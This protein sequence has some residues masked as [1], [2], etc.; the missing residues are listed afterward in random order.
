MRA[1]LAF[2]AVVLAASGCSRPPDIDDVP[3]GSSVQVTRE[4]GALVEGRLS[5]RSADAVRVDVGPTTR[6]VP[7]RE[8]V[9]FRVKGPN[10]KDE[11]PPAARFREITVPAD[12]RMTVRLHVPVGSAISRPEEIVHGTL[13]RPIAV[14]GATVI[15]A[16]AEVFGVVTRAERA[17][18]VKGRA[19]LAFHFNRLVASGETYPLNARFVR[20][21]S[22]TTD[23]DAE[24][25]AIPATG[26][27]IV[28]AIIGGNKGAAIGAAAGGGAGAAWVL[29]TSGEEIALAPDTVLSLQTGRTFVVRVPL[30][31]L[32]RNAAR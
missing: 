24:K 23:R 3:V 21:A 26:G 31:N 1:V 12:A 28:G 19:S 29:S 32:K 7:R 30:A 4:D 5:E 18:K 22:S 14:D 9:D 6:A 15:P 25:I 17:G 20:T 2:T 13:A 16:G 8:I 27:A 11:P 10:T